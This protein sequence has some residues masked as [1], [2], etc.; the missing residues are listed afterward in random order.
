MEETTQIGFAA[1]ASDSANDSNEMPGHNSLL[2]LAAALIDLHQTSDAIEILNF[3]LEENDEEIQAWH[4]LTYSNIV[5]KDIEAAKDSLESG[6]E[7]S[8]N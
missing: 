1:G 7:V 4:L 6:R 2:S 3:I 8:V 5:S